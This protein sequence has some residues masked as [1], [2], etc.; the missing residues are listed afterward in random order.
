MSAGHCA[1]GFI[2]WVSSAGFRVRPL[3]FVFVHWFSFS[4]AGVRFSF[5]PGKGI[6]VQG[7]ISGYM[8]KKVK[9]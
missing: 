7:K 8:V 2:R 6:T 5:S 4:S 9:R 3:V 1:L